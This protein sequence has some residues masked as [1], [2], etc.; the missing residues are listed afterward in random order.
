MLGT[1]KPTANDKTLW[2]YKTKTTWIHSAWKRAKE[3]CP[4]LDEAVGSS[5][6][7]PG[8]QVCF[9]LCYLL[10]ADSKHTSLSQGGG[11]RNSN[12]LP[13]QQAAE[14]SPPPLI[15]ITSGR[16]LVC[17]TKVDRISCGRTRACA[18]APFLNK[19]SHLMARDVV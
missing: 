4:G 15:V 17:H 1:Q 2:I 14:P 13:S 3:S 19:C 8:S 11:R 7:S 5:P 6:A 18:W 10:A 12:R 16:L 9:Q